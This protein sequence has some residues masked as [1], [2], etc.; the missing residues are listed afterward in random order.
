MIPEFVGRLPIIASL[1]ELEEKH[2]I[3][4]LAVPKNA[5]V[6]QYQALFELENVQLR[7]MDEA[8][9]AV[10]QEAIKRKSGARGLRTILER[11]MLDIMYHIPDLDGLLECV[12]SPGVILGHEEPMYM[13]KKEE[14]AALS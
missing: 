4:I 3:Q 14:K 5:L 13:Y 1:E 11:A 10:A 8:L 2:L 7:F 12:I 6:K 9:V